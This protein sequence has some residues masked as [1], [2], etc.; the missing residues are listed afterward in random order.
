MSVR[1]G[2][3]KSAGHLSAPVHGGKDAADEVKDLFA[4]EDNMICG[5]GQIS[6]WLTEKP[7]ESSFRISHATNIDAEAD[8]YLSSVAAEINALTAEAE[9]LEKE[10]Q[11]AREKTAPQEL[12]IQGDAKSTLGHILDVAFSSDEE[13]SGSDKARA[14]K[15]GQAKLAIRKKYMV[16]RGA[17]KAAKEMMDEELAQI[18]K[19]GEVRF[20]DKAGDS[21]EMLRMCG[22]LV[23][24]D[25]SLS[26]D[27][28]SYC[29]ELCG[30]FVRTSM[31]L[32]AKFAGS[33]AGPAVKDLEERLA[34]VQADLRYNNDEEAECKRAR[35]S[36][37][38]FVKELKGLNDDI[39]AKHHLRMDA[40][41]KLDEAEDMLEQMTE[42]QDDRTDILVRAQEDY[43]LSQ[44]QVAEL[45]ALVAAE[46]AKEKQF[47]NA[48]EVA[49]GQLDLASLDLARAE[50]A[51]VSLDEIKGLVEQTMVKMYAYHEVVVVR[52][53]QSLGL[54]M[55]FDGLMDEATSEKE[56]VYS[57]LA[58]MDKY[59]ETTA[60]KS[61]KKVQSSLDVSSLCEKGTAKEVGD[62]IND[63]VKQ[64]A[65]EV[66]KAL[67]RVQSKLDLYKGQ[68]G[69]SKEESDRLTSLGEPEGLREV[70][71]VYA[72]SSYYSKYL[73][74][75]KF[76]AMPPK[77][78]DLIASLH[79]TLDRLAEQEETLREAVEDALAVA[80]EQL[81]NRKR[82]VSLLKTAIAENN[83][84]KGK[85]AD[86]QEEVDAQE[87]IIQQQESNIEALEAAFKA[88]TEAYVAAKG[89][90]KSTYKRG[91]NM[92]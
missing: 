69:M 10:I 66:R 70:A 42:T 18:F 15:C 76:D 19:N 47:N 20:G 55:C 82:T 48:V 43:R 36:L 13:T 49:K 25:Q 63:M 78:L 34:K 84:A 54:K 68:E 44:E 6:K 81:R 9:R 46:K 62:Q 61:F 30:N 41:D 1:A 4:D 52:P 45:T 56:A 33:Y 22:S 14:V 75:W 17:Y 80:A 28:N 86:A 37:G 71:T 16:P 8:T 2:T 38:A 7:A 83:I 12:D 92:K 57:T 90:L 39:E 21:A 31:A 67:E 59:C 51:S 72:E 23:G 74:H 60:T 89:L 64:R 32:S 11:V 91:T 24:W 77:F 29:D 5:G 26:S 58:I 35:S 27:D 73:A 53:V 85:E 65:G 79:G 50:A 40:Q 88:A 3:S 87:Q